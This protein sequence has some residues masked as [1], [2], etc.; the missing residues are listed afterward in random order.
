MFPIGCGPQG[1]H[2]PLVLGPG[3]HLV[4][5]HHL[6]ALH[7]AQHLVG[8]LQCPRTREG[9]GARQA[10][11]QAWPCSSWPSRHR[12]HSS[13]TRLRWLAH[14]A[15]HRWHLPKAE[16]HTWVRMMPGQ[17]LKQ[18]GEAAPALRKG[19]CADGVAGTVPTAL[20]SQAQMLSLS[21]GRCPGRR[22]A[23]SPWI[24]GVLRVMR[25]DWLTTINNTDGSCFFFV[26]DIFEASTT[27]WDK[28]CYTRF[29]DEETEAAVTPD[30]MPL[31]A[32]HSYVWSGEGRTAGEFLRGWALA[33]AE[34]AC[35][36]G[37]N[38]SACSSGNPCHNW[39]GG[40]RPVESS[41][42]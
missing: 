15:A 29:T 19:L 35:S 7:L 3:T 41:W 40:E 31:G 5:Q 28:H 33:Q 23:N 42:Y 24:S 32:H 21:V 27:L 22:A 16:T 11:R 30:Q 34:P 6:A 1:L 17:V 10:G 2:Q 12:A 8:R 18:W 9:A 25:K 4:R 36:E 37:S 39:R 26:P 14:S 20:D 38:S 13:G